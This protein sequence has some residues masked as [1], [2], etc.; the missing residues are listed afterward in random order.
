MDQVPSL[1]PA[2]HTLSSTSQASLSHSFG[3]PAEEQ[4]E[5]QAMAYAYQE[6]ISV[7]RNSASSQTAG[8]SCLNKGWPGWVSTLLT[9]YG[10]G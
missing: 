4:G 1:N 6:N 5:G 8:K 10:W 9:S 7:L 3:S 2:F